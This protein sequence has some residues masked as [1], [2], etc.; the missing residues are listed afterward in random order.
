[1]L[2][3]VVRFLGVSV[4]TGTLA[5]CLGGGG[6]ITP[7]PTSA[8]GS[9][10]TGVVTGKGSGNTS[11][12]A[13]PTGGGASSGAASGGTGNVPSGTGSRSGSTVGT[14]YA[15]GGRAGIAV[16]STA[17]WLRTGRASFSGFKFGHA[18]TSNVDAKVQVTGNSKSDR[19]LTVKIDGMQRTFYNCPNNTLNC[20]YG[21]PF[22]MQNPS[23]AEDNY[24]Y[25]DEYTYGMIGTWDHVSSTN[26]RNNL[27]VVGNKSVTVPTRLRATYVGRAIYST[28][29]AN[30]QIAGVGGTAT[31]QRIA[32]YFGVLR[33]NA[34]FGTG[35]MT[36]VM[37]QFRQPGAKN[38]N[39]T[40]LQL[41]GRIYGNQISYDVS[42]GVKPM[43]S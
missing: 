35:Q 28:H 2:G 16:Y 39:R 32:K 6:G 17:T 40:V 23:A 29:E 12:T 26:V 14:A 20:H 4:L 36:A 5:G 37:D 13:T 7:I 33:M 38:S 3:S 1:M 15:P 43:A 21:V 22:T 25:Y 41:N 24:A 18:P 9:S 8:G 34:D 30:A 31:G 42:G 11:A 19:N 27:Y 10:S